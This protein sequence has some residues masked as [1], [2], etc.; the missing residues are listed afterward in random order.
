MNIL[1]EKD[2]RFKKKFEKLIK[3]KN[4]S[5]SK[6]IDRDVKK[7]IYSVVKNG[8][9]AIIKFVKKYDQCKINKNKILIDSKIISHHA[10]KVNI[11]TLESFKLAIKGINKYHKKQYPKNY[12]I[13]G[14]GYHLSQRWTPIDSVGLYV[15]G[16][17]ASYPSSLIMNIVPAKIAGVKRI[18]VVTPSKK[19]KF[20][21]YIMILITI[22]IKMFYLK[23]NLI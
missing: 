22:F 13:K 18:V 6:V 21:S 12:S 3:N 11:K 7:I 17:K 2:I 19:G 8:D 15:P 10:R 9:D 1:L 14:R 5:T 20:N 4:L 23:Y 16:G